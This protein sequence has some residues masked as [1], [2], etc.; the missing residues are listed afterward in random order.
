MR[1]GTSHFKQHAQAGKQLCTFYDF[2]YALVLHLVGNYHSP[3]ITDVVLIQSMDR[4]H[5]VS[6]HMP[7]TPAKATALLENSVG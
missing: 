5:T 4:L 7:E 1:S 2:K 3:H 6:V